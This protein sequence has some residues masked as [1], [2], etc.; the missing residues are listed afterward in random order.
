MEE[1]CRICHQRADSTCICEKNF[2]LCFKHMITHLETSKGQH[3]QI[4]LEMVKFIEK[5]NFNL[6]KINDWS[7]I[8]YN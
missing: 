2:F 4:S 3:K 1:T 6:K 8:I 7:Y 5:C